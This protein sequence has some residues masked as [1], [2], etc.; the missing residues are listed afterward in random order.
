MD[1]SPEERLLAAAKS[2]TVADY[3]SKDPA[4]NDPAN[5]AKWGPQRSISANTIY[6][7]AIGVRSDWPVHSKGIQITGARITGSLDFK[8]AQIKYPILLNGC[9]LDQLIV[10]TDASARTIN[11]IGSRVAGIE[12]DH[13]TVDG[14]VFLG[15]GFFAEGVVSMVSAGIDGA[16]VCTRGT[17]A[18]GLDGD[19]L[20]VNDAFLG[21]GFIARGTVRLVGAKIDGALVCK[22]GI[23]EAGLIAG[24][25]KAGT[26]FLDDGF[27]GKG[28]V[29]LVS[30]GIDGYL[31]CTGGIFAAGLTAAAMKAGSVSFDGKFS[32]DGEVNL[33]SARIDGDLS[34]TGGTFGG[35]LTAGSI[36]VGSIFLDGG[37]KAAGAVSLVGAKIDGALVCKG[38][39]FDKG[40]DA[41]SVKVGN[42]FLGEGFTA[43]GAVGLVGAEID[44]E[45]MCGRGIFHGGLNASSV[46]AGGVSLDRGFKADG[47]VSLLCARISGALDCVG[48][49]FNGSLDLRKASVGSL[50]DDPKS[51]PVSGRL[52]LDGFE[53][54]LSSSEGV[55]R[56]AARRLDWIERGPADPFLPQPYEQLAKVLHAIGDEAGARKVSIREQWQLRRCG[57]LGVA[58]RVWNW[59]LYITVGYGYRAWL[60]IFWAVAVMAF[61]ALVFRHAPVMRAKDS[62]APA[63]ASAKAS[64]SQNPPDQIA[65][66][67]L[68][69]PFLYSIDVFLPF[70]DLNQ[71]KTWQLDEQRSFFIAYQVWYLFEEL[72]GWVLTGLLAAAATG[73][74]KN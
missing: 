53:Y 65:D 33:V 59:F 14:S 57:R 64:G 13:L 72:A 51:W 7:L 36:K 39:T 49:T 15:D 60:S 68:P 22:S 45:L 4:E 46:K 50:A 10:L 18:G 52:L 28:E 2:G 37:F 54:D 19:N 63:V 11:L 30:A 40:I 27:T 25:M 23:F 24:S 44:G 56:D 55:P 69:H 16:L 70:A 6:Q 48:G 42:V 34:C 71:K 35:G 1:P 31:S 73:L 12:A 8:A 47:E 74:L 58:A 29:N 17:L 5:G 9:Y 21:D 32:A 43:N 61:G 66:T 3:Y 62:D 20:R 41:S 26:I 67:E 38:G